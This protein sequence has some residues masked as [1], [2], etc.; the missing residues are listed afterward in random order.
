MAPFSIFLLI[1]LLSSKAAEIHDGAPPELSPQTAELLDLLNVYGKIT[2]EQYI[3][4]GPLL[5]PG[6]VTED[7][8]LQQYAAF[9]AAEGQAISVYN[10]A[11]AELTALT[12]DLLLLLNQYEAFAVSIYQF[13]FEEQLPSSPLEVG[14]RVPE[15]ELVDWTFAPVA[16]G[17]RPT[18]VPEFGSGGTME[19]FR[20]H[21]AP[22]KLYVGPSGWAK[23]FPAEPV[24]ARDFVVDGYQ[25]WG[26]NAHG[27]ASEF[28]EYATIRGLLRTGMHIEHGDYRGGQGGG[29]KAVQALHQEWSK[30]HERRS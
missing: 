27:V 20:F 30:R 14:C 22:G 11:P 21:P 16:G 4:D 26:S 3:F 24:I 7:E 9:K 1:N 6:N 28:I 2:V 23:S 13:D 18:A 17:G 8:A 29:D 19:G 10:Q 25:T 12:T 5:N 15:A